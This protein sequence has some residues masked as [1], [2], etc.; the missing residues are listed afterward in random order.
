[1]T[2]ICGMEVGIYNSDDDYLFF[3]SDSRTNDEHEEKRKWNNEQKMFY[4]NDCIAL[5]TG[6]NHEIEYALE[7]ANPKTN[8]TAKKFAQIVA[9]RIRRTTNASERPSIIMGGR[10]ESLDLYYINSERWMGIVDVK[11]TKFIFDGCGSTRAAEYANKNTEPV[12][13]FPDVFAFLYKLA[14]VASEDLNVG[15]TFQFGVMTPKGASLILPANTSCYPKN[16]AAYIKLM[17]GFEI[18]PNDPLLHRKAHS[19]N[20]TIGAYHHA[21]TT[22]LS[23]Y[24]QAKE[25]LQKGT[26]SWREMMSQ[27]QHIDDA[28]G[29]LLEHDLSTLVDYTHEFMLRQSKQFGI[30]LALEKRAQCREKYL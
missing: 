18:D 25:Q 17:S 8:N 3:I 5:G 22:D 2:F 7:P 23:L 28:I 11:K 29:A 27:K 12:A 4:V 30:A 15:D 14:Q 26:G 19:I 9:R 10:N 6:L 13:D 1:M 20:T 16:Y 24:L 21:L